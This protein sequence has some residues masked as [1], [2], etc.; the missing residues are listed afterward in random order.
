VDPAPAVLDGWLAQRT[1]AAAGDYLA[2]HLAELRDPAVKDALDGMRTAD[3]DNRELAAYDVVLN[4]AERFGGMGDEVMDAWRPGATSNA[5]GAPGMAA[6]PPPGPVPPWF[7]TEFLD[8]LE[9]YD[10]RRGWNDALLHLLYTGQLSGPAVVT[11]SRALI[12]PDGEPSAVD[13]GTTNAKVFAATAAVLAMTPQE[14]AESWNEDG[15]LFRLA[16]ELLQNC[17]VTPTDRWLSVLRIANLRDL[18]A[19][20]GRAG[21]FGPEAAGPHRDLLDLLATALSNC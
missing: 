11:L 7:L 17:A 6:A 1:W 18:L 9:S 3:P 10:L 21:E 16:L 13:H 8:P 15:G 19:A 14:A 2:E 12:A 20:R 5:L 4:A